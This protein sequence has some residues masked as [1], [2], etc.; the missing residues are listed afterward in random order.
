[1]DG[2]HPG[3]RVARIH[4]EG[5]MAESRSS[6]RRRRRLVVTLCGLAV[7]ASSAAAA[8][9]L[10]PFAFG[11]KTSPPSG[12]Q[13]EN[14]SITVGCHLTYDRFV[15]RL[16]FGGQSGYRVRY[17]NQII[18]DGSGLPVPLLGSKNLSV[19]L[20]NA[21][22]HRINGISSLVPNVIT[23]LCANLRQVKLAGDFE[24]VVSYGL[25][26]KTK[27]AFRVFKLTNPKRIVIDVHH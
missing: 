10:P 16:R 19:V 8:W 4:K 15:I 24:G 7:F 13:T 6:T 5:T 20:P 26:L 21:R 18:S 12:G 22:A 9:A 14:Y 1:M 3:A 23:P 27:G 11:L 2:R 25:G 17:V